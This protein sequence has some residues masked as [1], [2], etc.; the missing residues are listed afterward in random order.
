MLL[1]KLS[2]SP[3]LSSQ[4]LLS[5]QK[6]NIL[7]SNIK[8]SDSILYSEMLDISVLSAADNNSTTERYK[9]SPKYR[10]PSH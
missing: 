4:T 7:C 10:I 6:Y 3:L 8:L 5:K 2:I 9:G 1:T